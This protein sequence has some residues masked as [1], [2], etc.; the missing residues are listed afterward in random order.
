MTNKNP[1]ERIS[2]YLYNST[3]VYYYYV[4]YPINPTYQA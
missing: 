2:P 3:V 4:V 1:S